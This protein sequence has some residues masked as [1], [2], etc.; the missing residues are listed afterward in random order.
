MKLAA[1][2]EAAELPPPSA[3]LLGTTL[4]DP[5]AAVALLRAASGRHPDDAWVNHTLA[6]RLGE[7]RPAP[8]EEQVR[9]YAMA[10]A[11]RPESAHELAHLLDDMGRTDEALAVFADLVGPPPRRRPA[12]HV[13]RC[14][15]ERPRP[16]RGDEAAACRRREAEEVLA[17]A[18]SAGREAVRLRPQDARAHVSLGNALAEQGKEDEAIAAYREAVRLEPDSARPHGNLGHALADQRTPAKAI[19]AYPEAIAELREAIRLDPD[20]V[21]SHLN[22]GYVLGVHG[23]E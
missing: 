9:Y 7:L 13:L 23:E 11:V 15:P 21:L 18:V 8:R 12:P 2:P 22:L 20:D 10:R 4:K 1:S 6:K 14:L 5:A 19:A 3:V 17:R 16:T